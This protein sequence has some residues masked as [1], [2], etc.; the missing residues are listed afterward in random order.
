MKLARLKPRIGMLSVRT[1]APITQDRLRGRR[2]LE[3]NERYLSEHPCCAHC[4]KAGRM[5]AATEVDHIVPLHLGGAD[6]EPN[7][8]GLCHVCHVAK[9]SAEHA[10]RAGR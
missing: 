3:R 9:T 2:R 1:A 8:Q 7:L 4:Q 5:R 6:A 10:A